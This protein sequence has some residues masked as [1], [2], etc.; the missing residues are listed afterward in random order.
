MSPDVVA[1]SADQTVSPAVPLGDRHAPTRVD[2][3]LSPPIQQQ[4]QRS[5]SKRCRG[6]CAV[7]G[8][9]PTSNGDATEARESGDGGTHSGQQLELLAR[10]LHQSIG[11]VR[12]IPLAQIRR[13]QLIPI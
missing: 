5:G 7:G 10:R 6:A 3:A 1:I 13:A 9:P 8:E 11:K 12:Q 2:P 4:A